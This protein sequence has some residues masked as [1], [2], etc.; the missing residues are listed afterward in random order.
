MIDFNPSATPSA[1]NEPKLS[2]RKPRRAAWTA[3]LGVA[4]AVA[5]G[6]AYQVLPRITP[7]AP[8]A[9]PASAAIPVSVALV[10]QRDTALWSDFSGRIEAVG[11]VEVRPRAAGAII[12][13]HFRE[14]A[15]VK[16]GDLLFTIDPAPYAVEVQRN[17]AQVAAAVARLALAVK[18]QQRAQQLV[19]S[20]FTPQRDVD[21]RVNEFHGAEANLRATQATLAT[22]RLNLATPWSARPLPAGLAGSR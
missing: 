4:A 21:Q 9:A 3:G 18:E 1:V 15:M 7:Q 6:A 13:A 14:G 20:G 2:R 19:G 16:Q 22:A 12:Q 17:E 5:A 10:E 8:A 11:R